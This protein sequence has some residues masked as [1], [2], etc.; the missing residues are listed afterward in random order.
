MR[1][2]H[3]FQRRAVYHPC[4]RN[5]RAS[6]R[7]R[8][9]FG[10]Y[11]ARPEANQKPQSAGAKSP[12]PLRETA[13][14]PI[15]REHI[16]MLVAATDD[17]KSSFG[18][19]LWIG[20]MPFGFFQNRRRQ[21]RIRYNPRHRHCADHRRNR[22]DCCGSSVSRLHVTILFRDQINQLEKSG[23]GGGAC[24][25]ISACQLA[26][27]RDKRTAIRT[28]S[29]LG[30][31]IDLEDRLETFLPSFLG[32]SAL[33]QF[34]GILHACSTGFSHQLILRVKMS[35]KPPVSEPRRCHNPCE[36]RSMNAFLTK[37][38]GRCCDNAVPRC[39]G[40]DF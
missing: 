31:E 38:P 30:R 35:V 3:R 2:H 7:P 22:K 10:C 21:F 11:G 20:Q 12:R 26:A 9:Y 15:A 40:F 28:I 17:T 23:R 33:R 5:G 8:A 32:R 27:E 6:P 39:R 18:R 1:F 24:L 37:F 13:S 4:G 19:P 25:P 34:N 14:T 16:M 36:P 29:M